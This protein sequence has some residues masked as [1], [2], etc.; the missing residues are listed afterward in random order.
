VS[1]RRATLP[2]YLGGFL[3]PFGGAV[4]AVLIPELRHA[5]HAST[6]EIALAV[7]AYLVPFALLQV[8]SGTIGERVGRRRTVSVAY[9]VY[10]AAML[11]SA[12][13]PSIDVF[14][15]SRALQGTA[16]A[17]TTPLLL[18]GLADAVPSHQRGRAVG[19]FAGVQAGGLSLAP[20]LGGLAAE[21]S[22]RLAFILP[23][24]LA[25]GLMLV[26]PPD[27]VRELGAPRVAF[28]S[29]MTPRM[30]ILCVA[31]FAGYLGMAGLAF[32]ISLRAGD[33]FS[34]S[35]TGRGVL[36]ATYGA[37]GL[38][39]GRWGGLGSERLGPARAAGIGAVMC[40]VA[41][42]PLGVAPSALAMALLW[43]AGGAASALLW[44]AL[45]TISVEAVPAN[46][47]GAVSLFA[48]CK[49]AGTA[50]APVAWLPVYDT[51]PGL[52]FALAGVLLLTIVPLAPA[53]LRAR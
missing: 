43:F 5:F 20:L 38:A 11:L 41:V 27:P 52:T 34:L 32:L 21:I 9:L 13:A 33:A 10:A 53:A 18:A 42:A 49:F 15:A 46:R 29:V 48:A 25:L 28:R 2:L 31:G 35:P 1:D 40:A 17:F 36:L 39:F 50:V 30:A 12:V 47:G 26:P 23:A 19:T 16:N 51:S 4:L 37:A 44:A 24:V 6:D 22:W 3:G 7:P 14:L 45:N 8:V